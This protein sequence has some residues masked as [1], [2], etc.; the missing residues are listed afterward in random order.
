[1]VFMFL[2]PCRLLVEKHLQN[3]KQRGIKIHLE[4]EVDR[5][6]G[7]RKNCTKFR[8]LPAECCPGN[9]RRRKA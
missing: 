7:N 9:Q 5:L 3:L 8:D 2:H 1:M 6:L 4:E